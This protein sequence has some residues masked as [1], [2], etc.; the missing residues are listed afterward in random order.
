[1]LMAT[2][3]S[4]ASAESFESAFEKEFAGRKRV[5]EDMRTFL[6]ALVYLMTTC[7]VAM[8]AS[9]AMQLGETWWFKAVIIATAVGIEAA[10]VFFSAVIYP[11]PVLR[12]NQILAGVLL[13]VV[14]IF[15]VASFMVSQQFAQDH[16]VQEMAK[17]YVQ[18][19]NADAANLSATNQADRGSLAAVR[20]RIEGMFRDLRGVKGSK[21][22]AIYHYIADTI[23]ASVEAVVLAVRLMWALCFVSL[24]IALD[25]YV[26]T[27]S[28]SERGMEKWIEAWQRERELFERAKAWRPARAV[29]SG[30]RDEERSE[31]ETDDEREVPILHY[32]APRSRGERYRREAVVEEGIDEETY[33]KIRA[34]VI[35]GEISPSVRSVLKLAKGMDRTYSAIDRL[36]DEGVVTQAENGRYRLATA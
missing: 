18:S 22:T 7:A 14:S 5:S 17:G 26:D 28:Y 19:L 1:M 21:A 15:T 12:V 27:R 10:V 16:A 25:A 35:N 23:G 24:C 6:R 36:K 32:S 2:A 33:Q 20:N 34:A 31:V 8:A 4:T 3:I 13:P 11:A 29:A 30:P 9:Y